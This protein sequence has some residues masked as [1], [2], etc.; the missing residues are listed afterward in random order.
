MASRF[1]PVPATVEEARPGE[2]QAGARLRI[3]QLKN[4]EGTAAVDVVDGAAVRSNPIPAVFDWCN[5]DENREVAR[6][7]EDKGSGEKNSATLHVI[8]N[9][10]IDRPGSLTDA[11]PKESIDI[12]DSALASLELEK[13]RDTGQEVRQTNFLSGLEKIRERTLGGNMP[14]RTIFKIFADEIAP[15]LETLELRAAR[16]P[17]ESEEFL[18]ARVLAHCLEQR[19][20]LA[21]SRGLSDAD[22]PALEVR[23]LTGTLTAWIEVG[24]PD[25]ARL[26]RASKAAGRVAVYTHHDAERYWATLADAHIHRAETLELYGL[27]RALVAA[28][29]ERLA[30]RM[31]FDLSVSDGTLYVTLGDELL[32]GTLA[33]HRLPA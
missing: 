10:P 21:F 25:A 12:V 22:Q 30:R 9:V 3:S 32:T 16:H 20:G 33:T 15:E 1:P 27:D 17:S 11:P 31:A 24:A 28:L 2:A 23:D 8:Y 13:Q 29:V 7:L 26:H 4:Y 14:G 19:E 18:V 5:L 6:A